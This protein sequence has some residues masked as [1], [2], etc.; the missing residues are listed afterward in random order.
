M[1][2]TNQELPVFFHPR[3]HCSKTVEWTEWILQLGL[4]HHIYLFASK[5]SKGTFRKGAIVT[6]YL[7]RIAV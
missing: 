4:P 7:I 5:T 3:R 6:D 1:A 2:P